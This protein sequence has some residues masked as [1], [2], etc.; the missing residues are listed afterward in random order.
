MK[1]LHEKP[2]GKQPQWSNDELLAINILEEL[3]EES[4]GEKGKEEHAL[5]PKS[6]KFPPLGLC[7]N[8]DLFVQLMTREIK[9]ITHF[10]YRD[11]LTREQR[12]ALNELKHMKSVV[13][14]P[15]D[16]EGNVVLLAEDHL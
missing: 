15:V 2:G 8:V 13:F 16:K 6:K 7:P 11:N 9:Q 1:K 3:E 14:K 5:K 12:C 10:I 4:L